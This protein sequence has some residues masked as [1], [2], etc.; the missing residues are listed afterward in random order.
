MCEAHAVSRPTHKAHALND[1]ARYKVQRACL[2]SANGYGGW[3]SRLYGDWK[4]SRGP[5]ETMASLV[6][7][8][9]TATHLPAGVVGSS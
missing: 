8:I 4:T 9:R 5:R 1:K 7:L 6:R 2:P 3:I